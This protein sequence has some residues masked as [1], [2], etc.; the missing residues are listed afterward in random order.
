MNRRDLLRGLGAMAAA[1]AFFPKAVLGDVEIT[2]ADGTKIV[3]SD[4]TAKVAE[5][6]RAL[7]AEWS[8]AFFETPEETVRQFEKVVQGYKD[9]GYV[10]DFLVVKNDEEE[11]TTFTVFT[12]WSD[13]R[14]LHFTFAISSVEIDFRA[15]ANEKRA[16]RP[17]TRSQ[18]R[19]QG[20]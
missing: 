19:L 10:K 6:H 1:M 20:S 8:K 17:G 5:L 12:R 13:D 14:P 3:V 16:K 11:T 4:L 2:R 9:T 7:V 18:A 15:I